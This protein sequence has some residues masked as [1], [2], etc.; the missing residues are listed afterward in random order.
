MAGMPCKHF[1]HLEKIGPP[2][3]QRV[4]DVVRQHAQDRIGVRL[5]EVRRNGLIHGRRSVEHTVFA[6][7]AEIEGDDVVI[8]P[9]KFPDRR[10]RTRVEL[11]VARHPQQRFRGTAAVAASVQDGASVEDTPTAAL[12]ATRIMTRRVPSSLPAVRTPSSWRARSAAA[13]CSRR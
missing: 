3:Q 7:S 1:H 10:P 9:R 12:A 5:A 6:K 8:R 2:R 4:V 13:P 11:A